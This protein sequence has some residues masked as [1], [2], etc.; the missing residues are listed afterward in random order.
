MN[1]FPTDW[2]RLREPFDHAARS[3]TLVEILLGILPASRPL[4]ILELAAGLGSGM[5]FL[6]PLLPIPQ[7]WIMIDHDPA[8]LASISLPSTN[9]ITLEIQEFDLRELDKL[10]FSADL[11]STQALLDLVS[12]DWLESLVNHLADR[13]LPLLAALTVDGR[14]R[15][16][17]EDPR[18]AEIQQ[19]FRAHQTGDRGFGPSVGTQ[20]TQE[21][22][23]LF[24]ARNYTIIR[25]QADWS[26]APACTRM[27]E[28]LV[29]GTAEAA[30][31]A[32][33]NITTTKT[34]TDWHRSRRAAISS[35]DLSLQIGHLDL[36]ALP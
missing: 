17:P 8:L 11:V 30:M 18:D 33:G 27:L 7:H 34:L 31:E 25:K 14:I 4:R 16:S 2:L 21:L 15:W 19:A 1:R 35:G 28:E 23:R 9:N 22:E 20:A 32:C 24:S 13:R 12:N 29:D 6:A 26:I 36:L 5:R 3:T 10:D